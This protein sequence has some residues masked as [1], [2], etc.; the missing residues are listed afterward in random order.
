MARAQG[1]PVFIMINLGATG[2]FISPSC[3]DQLRLRGV[4]KE[5]PEP[6]NGL[7]REDLGTQKLTVES[8]I[9]PLVVKGR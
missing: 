7:S 6:I 5:R 4:Q 2:N 3:M 8:G 9:I 1:K